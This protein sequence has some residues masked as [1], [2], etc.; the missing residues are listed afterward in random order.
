M[1][2]V[3]Q[4]KGAIRYRHILE[5]INGLKDLGKD[6][7][8]CMKNGFGKLGLYDSAV[9]LNRYSHDLK[10]GDKKQVVSSLKTMAFEALMAISWKENVSTL[11]VIMCQVDMYALKNK[12]YGNSFSECFK[13]FG[14]LYSFGHIVE[15]VNRILSL[16]ILDD[17]ADDEPI[18]DSYKDLLGYCVL[19]IME[20]TKDEVQD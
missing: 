8:D 19:T 17:D 9:I 7:V 20:L 2:T 15:K 14:L 18:L 13:R 12:R 5:D 4:S 3:E 16:L 6:T 11:N 1:D 10:C